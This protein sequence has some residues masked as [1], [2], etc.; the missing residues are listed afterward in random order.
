[1]PSG[2]PT[3]EHLLGGQFGRVLIGAYVV[4]PARAARRIFL[5]GYVGIASP[6][7]GDKFL[8]ASVAAVVVGGASILGGSGSYLGPWPAR[9][10]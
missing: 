2:Q 10:C 6:G 3:R 8:S 1:M 9:C 5:V 7:L 4:S